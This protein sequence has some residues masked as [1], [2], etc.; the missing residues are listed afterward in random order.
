MSNNITSK[1]TKNDIYEAYKK[2]KDQ[3]DNTKTETLKEKI[4]DQMLENIDKSKSVKVCNLNKAIEMINYV[5]SLYEKYDELDTA[6][7]MKKDKLKELEGIEV[8]VNTLLALNQS[9]QELTIKHEKLMQEID[10]KYCDKNN[11][12]E[13]EYKLKEKETMTNLTRKYEE[14]EYELNQKQKKIMDTFNE[15]LN[16]KQKDMKEKE[17]NLKQ[18]IEIVTER[19]LKIDNLEKELEKIKQ[20]RLKEI[21]DA[22][23]EAVLQNSDNLNNKHKHA[24]E[25]LE[26][27]KDAMIEKLESKVESLEETLDNEETRNVNLSEEL[28]DAYKQIESIASKSVS[29]AS[30]KNLAT[31]LE[32]ILKQNR[33]VD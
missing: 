31:S 7:N 11:E 5:K 27:R 29:S 10:D 32:K 23:E 18:R 17:I 25:V 3:L 30:D 13:K 9:N 12:L 21:E 14:K 26:L 2:L 6:I 4:N 22:V 8:G 1:S 19:E 16:R 24:I 33:K 15:D 20:N 28:K